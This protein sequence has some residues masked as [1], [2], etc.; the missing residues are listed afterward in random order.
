[1]MSTFFD[2]PTLIQRWLEPY[3]A[4]RP[5]DLAHVVRK[6]MITENRVTSLFVPES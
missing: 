5:E 4:A 1:M 3:R 6:Y 2:D